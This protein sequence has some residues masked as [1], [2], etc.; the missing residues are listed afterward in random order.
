MIS[1]IHKAFGRQNVGGNGHLQTLLRKCPEKS[2]TRD[3]QLLTLTSNND[4]MK[5]VF[6][7]FFGA[8]IRK[9]LTN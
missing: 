8:K 3:F 9:T 5:S 2:T 6:L 7:Y 4:V 1:K